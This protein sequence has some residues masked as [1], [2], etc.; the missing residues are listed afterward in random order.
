MDNLKIGQEIIMTQDFEI[1]TAICEKKL[2]VKKG[3]KAYIDSKGFVHYVS[4]D[5]RG[6]IQGIKDVQLKGYDTENIA[7]LIYD[8]LRSRYYIKDFLQDYDI[9]KEDFISEIDWVLSEIL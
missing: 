3:D 1:E 4:G 7:K 5:A 8:R 6:K 9:S 2:L